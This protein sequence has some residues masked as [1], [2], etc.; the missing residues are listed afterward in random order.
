MN[1]DT[2]DNTIVT[3]PEVAVPQPAANEHLGSKYIEVSSLTT[4]DKT[5][6]PTRAYVP[7]VSSR[8]IKFPFRKDINQ[9]IVLYEG[10]FENIAVDALICP[11]NER[12]DDVGGP[13]EIIRKY[14]GDE[15]KRD[16]VIAGTCRM[17]ECKATPAYNIGSK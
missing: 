10:N 17:S 16:L 8:D 12:M 6:E 4:W 15:L 11:T 14:G 1:T 3:S 7:E 9:R 13:H 2:S 5:D